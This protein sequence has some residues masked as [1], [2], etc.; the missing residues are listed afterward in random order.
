VTSFLLDVNVLVSLLNSRSS[1]HLV[2]R[3]WFETEGHSSWLTCPITQNGT[4]RILTSPS[5]SANS[6]TFGAAA[7]LLEGLF[8]LGHH[9]F[10]PNDLSLLDRH[11]IDRSVNVTPKQSADVYLLAMA[12]KH[13]ATFATF[14]RN[15][16]ARAV[17]GG[18]DHLLML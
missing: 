5:T 7:E 1:H 14:D 3:K 8:T 6:I 2:A 13:E 4:I 11:V 12:T 16:A 18:N 15:V 10:I 9:R 17:R